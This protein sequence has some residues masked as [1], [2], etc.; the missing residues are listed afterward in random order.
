M[1]EFF[2]A[3]VGDRSRSGSLK[4]QQG[5]FQLE[6]RSLD[7]EGGQALKWAPRGVMA[8]PSLETFQS[9]LDRCLLG[10]TELGMI[11]PGAG[12]LD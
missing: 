12:G 5:K 8:S 3:A 9:R 10:M 11:L 4:L 7:P 1:N 2:F 6:M